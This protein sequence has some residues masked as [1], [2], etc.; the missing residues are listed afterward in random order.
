MKSPKKTR[1]A[2]IL[3][4][5]QAI[6]WLAFIALCVQTGILFYAFVIQ[7]H[8]DQSSMHDTYNNLDVYELFLNNTKGYYLLAVLV[9]LGC[10][11]KTLLLFQLTRIFSKVNFENPFKPIL[12]SIIIK[13]SYL[14]L[15]IGMLTYFE[16]RLSNVLSNKE[17]AIA[18]SEFTESPKVFIL[19]AG[20]LFIIAQVLKRGVEI[21]AENDLTI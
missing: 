10:F 19:F 1:T 9:I 7:V 6:S 20:V 12:A 16:V 4:F 11:F 14:S 18:I 3:Q 5:M 8:I 21:Q 17:N 13:M 15:T 2:N